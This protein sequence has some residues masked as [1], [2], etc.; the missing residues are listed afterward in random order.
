MRR[1]IIV[2][3]ALV[4]ILTLSS[5]QWVVNQIAPVCPAGYTCTNTATAWSVKADSSA[6]GF[7]AASSEAIENPVSSAKCGYRPI[8]SGPRNALECNAPNVLTFTTRGQVQVLTLSAAPF[9]T[10]LRAPR[11][12]IPLE[13]R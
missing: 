8:A 1:I 10:A 12:P 7:V 6:L 13:A 9:P 11:V 3:A 2:I 4:S 5:C